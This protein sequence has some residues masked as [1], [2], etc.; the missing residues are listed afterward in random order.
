MN[1]PTPGPEQVTHLWDLLRLP[2]HWP[3]QSDL[4]Q[5]CQNMGPGSAAILVICGLIYLLFGW[6]IFRS[7]VVLNAAL[8]GAYIGARIG[9]MG[10]S[11]FAGACV[12]AFV[13]AAMA[14]PLMKYAVAFM[15]GVFGALLG[16][17][18]WRAVGLEPSLCWAGAL[19]GL[20]LFGLLSF[21]IFRGSVMMYMS[22][23]G[24]VMLIFGILGLIYKY[25]DVAPQVT[26]SMT[27]K[28]FLLPVAIFVPAVLGL[29]YQQT[30]FGE[31]EAKKK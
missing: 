12:G 22:L 17:S 27:L 9:E 30:Q 8:V 6:Y 4:L 29:I 1:P 5:W 13:A 28:P 24:S 15:G 18:L 20:I 7:L 19:S 3:V 2:G 26:E 11:F 23:Q 14:W 25:Q 16:A 10:G 21:I 31:L